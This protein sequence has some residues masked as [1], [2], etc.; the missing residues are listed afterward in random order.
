MN[1]FVVEAASFCVLLFGYGSF[2]PDEKKGG[3]SS[4]SVDSVL[5]TN[6]VP[7]QFLVVLFTQFSII[8]WDRIVY[9]NRSIKLKLWTQLILLILVHMLL[10]IYVPR[11]IGFP[12]RNRITLVMFYFLKCLYFT[13]SGLQIHY[14]YPPHFTVSAQYL[15]RTPNLYGY[16]QYLIYRSIPFFF[17]VKTI[18]DWACTRTTLLLYDWLKLEDV[19]SSLYLVKCDVEYRKSLLRTKG[20]EYPGNWKVIVGGSA[21][22]GLILLLWLPLLLFTTGVQFGPDNAVFDASVDVRIEWPQGTSTFFS[23]MR[24]KAVKNLLPEE[25]VQIK[26]F[27]FEK[28]TWRKVSV[29]ADSFTVWDITPPA[30]VQLQE[31]LKHTEGKYN[32]NTGLNET[33]IRLRLGFTFSRAPTNSRFI[34]DGEQATTSDSS[35]RAPSGS[36]TVN[37]AVS[38]PLSTTQARK[39]ADI[40]SSDESS[41]TLLLPNLYVPFLLLP[42]T[43]T[44][45]GTCSLDTGHSSNLIRPVNCSLI[46]T[47]GSETNQTSANVDWWNVQCTTPFQKSESSYLTGLEFVVA[48]DSA[49]LGSIAGLSSLLYQVSIMGIY[50]T[51][52]FAFGRFLRYWVLGMSQRI[53]YEDLPNCD[54]LIQMC[55]DI[56]TAR[57]DGELKLEETLYEE[58]LEVYRNPTLMI[59]LTR[60]REEHAYHKQCTKQK[61]D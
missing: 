57:L 24:P 31:T 25:I 18:L 13:L 20:D 54:I 32:Q 41:R 59:R 6:Q 46:L 33:N 28:R 39:L 40:L 34:S 52:I 44:F 5:R 61:A 14:G 27:E 22:F 8:L 23:A 38:L 3:S 51:Y 49:I 56:F 11:T 26:P 50:I 19:Y 36:Q 10:F 30:R 60:C 29:F 2:V 42:A 7:L 43:E 4:L 58:L 16:Y 21:L 1:L 35:T 55:M 48:S 47:S 12:I 9:L 17:E 37:G 53:I 45:C 15:T